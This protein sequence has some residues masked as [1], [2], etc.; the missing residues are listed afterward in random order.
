MY[1]MSMGY[2][3]AAPTNNP[4]S[5]SAKLVTLGWAFFVLIAV[6]SYTANMASF[7]VATRNAMS[8]PSD[9]QHV[10]HSRIAWL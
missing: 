10:Q 8:G 7:L 2:F 4:K 5:V 9:I 6:S 1:L 3:S